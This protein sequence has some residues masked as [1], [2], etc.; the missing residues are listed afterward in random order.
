ME[1]VSSSETS[2]N[3]Y[4][5]TRRHI[6]DDVTVNIY[7]CENLRFSIVHGVIRTSNSWDPT[8]QFL[9]SGRVIASTLDEIVTASRIG[10][11]NPLHFLSS[12]HKVNTAM[13]LV[14]ELVN[15]SSTPCHSPWGRSLAQI[16]TRNT[17][18]LPGFPW[19]SSVPSGKCRVNIPNW[20]RSATFH[21]LSVLHLPTISSIWVT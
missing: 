15:V 21:F 2:M 13:A 6:K 8:A 14:L 18:I 5:I 7:R 12:R 1:A 10:F 19:V 3:F 4:R 20:D 16:S 9:E 17:V 11:W